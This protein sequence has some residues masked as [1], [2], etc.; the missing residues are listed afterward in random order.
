[1]LANTIVAV[2]GDPVC[3]SVDHRVDGKVYDLQSGETYKI[4]IRKQMKDDAYRSFESDSAQFD[5]GPGGGEGELELAPGDYY[6]ELSIVKNNVGRVI[7]PAADERGV[8]LNCL[9]VV[10]NL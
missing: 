5:V 1:M 4:T 8:R 10:R 9:S 7:S 2:E 3:F 6:F